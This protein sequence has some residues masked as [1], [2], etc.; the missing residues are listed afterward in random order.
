M[1]LLLGYDDETTMRHLVKYLEAGTDPGAYEFLDLNVFKSCK[2]FSV[3]HE[4]DLCLRV[5]DREYDFSR[6]HT[7][8]SRCYGKSVGEEADNGRTT[9]IIRLLG[10]YLDFCDK[11][12]VNRPSAGYSNYSKLLHSRRLK[13]FGFNVPDTFVTGSERRAKELLQPDENWVSKGAS[14]LRTR[15][16]PFDFRLYVNLDLVNR[17]PT[18]FQKRIKGYDVRVHVVGD[19][20]L[21][22]QIQA[23]NLDYRYDTAEN[24]YA[25]ILVPQDIQ[26]RC[27]AYC[28]QDGL[29]FAGIDFKVDEQGTWYVL[30]VNP[31]PGYNFFDKKMGNKIS[32]ALCEFLGR[33]A[34]VA[35]SNNGYRLDRPFIA[36]NR[37]TMS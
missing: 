14:S 10:N 36:I 33:G 25:E 6:Y 9:R 31:M 28:K 22:L 21:G 27:R 23:S 30:E 2:Q 26:D 19:R 32:E 1:F 34:A 18:L 37:R 35:A 3:S 4:K 17:C 7:I 29:L 5:D 8:F 24:E 12:V 15:A 13:D 16:V 11:R 20:I